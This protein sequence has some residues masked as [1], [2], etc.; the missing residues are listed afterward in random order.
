MENDGYQPELQKVTKINDSNGDTDPNVIVVET[1]PENMAKTLTVEY[2][3]DSNRNKAGSTCFVVVM[4]VIT[5][6]VALLA[7]ALCSYYFGT[8]PPQPSIPPTCLTK[9]CVKA[10]GR[11]L[12]TMNENV[13]PCED[14]YQYS[15]GGW[16]QNNPIPADKSRIGV[17]D[18]IDDRN[19]H[20]LKSIMEKSTD[21]VPSEIEK[22]SLRFYAACMDEE[23]RDEIGVSPLVDIVSGYGGWNPSS[24]DI[25]D[26]LA[27][28]ITNYAIGTLFDFSIGIDDYD[29]SRQM[30]MLDQPMLN[31]PDRSFYFR[32]D[33]DPV[34]LSYLKLMKTVL[35]ELGLEQ[36][37]LDNV[38]DAVWQFEVEVAQILVPKS[39]RQDILQL[40]N[41]LT[42]EELQ[43]SSPQLDWLHILNVL[44]APHVIQRSEEILIYATDYLIDLSILISNSD[45]RTIHNFMLW[46][47]V[48]P[49]S[50]M[51]SSKMYDAHSKV[52]NA[53]TG[54]TVAKE[55]W[56]IC[57]RTVG[58]HLDMP[59]GAMFIRETFGPE[60]KQK[61]VEIVDSVKSTF[62]EALSS[63]TADWMSQETVEAALDKVDAMGEKIGYPDFI[64]DPE[65][66]DKRYDEFVLDE[67]NYFQTVINSLHFDY[68]KMINKYQQ[69]VDKQEWLAPPHILNAY[70]RP[71][72]N[73]MTIMAAMLQSPIFDSEGPEG[74]NYA[75]LGFIVAH[76]LIHGFDTHGRLYNKYGSIA[77]WWS[78]ESTRIFDR[79][80]ECVA[81]QYSNYEV[82]G[83]NMKV[84]GNL[85]KGEN[86]ADLGAIKYAYNAY[87]SSLEAMGGEPLLP[88]LDKTNDQVFF[89]AFAQNWCSNLRERRA[90]LQLL[91]D[92]HSPEQYRVIGTLSQYEEFSHAFNCPLGSPM[93]PKDKCSVW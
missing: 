32:D 44:M 9:S 73:E 10:A 58:S 74:L 28:M 56:R 87:Q 52:I 41:K 29:S 34:V 91:T 79:R 30:L 31:L 84:D 42:I 5:L 47:L 65:E 18:Q 14:F 85:T 68:R 19:S 49:Y 88:A 48:A 24:T 11:M 75:R 17:L 16:L 83:I 25:D 45:H 67:S 6:S 51:T 8:D 89:I 81:E 60:Q 82:K 86:I 36:P 63:H 13:D 20:L 23:R 7:G 21:S 3:D 43:A 70:Y 80:T 40:Y 59:V 57:S 26:T 54:A 12:D 78:D 90:K 92:S 77:P 33:N 55:Q 66:L 35:S 93:N 71:S 53:I 2:T 72:A 50:K 61:V 4:M 62:R 27:H 38:T 46:Q 1:Q 15:C 76:E 39:E 37:T 69:P 22:K 64:L